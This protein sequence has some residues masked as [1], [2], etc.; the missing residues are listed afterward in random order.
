MSKLLRWVPRG[1]LGPFTSNWVSSSMRFALRWWVHDIILHHQD[2]SDEISELYKAY[3]LRT[4]TIQQW[5]VSIMV[6][7]DMFMHWGC[8]IGGSTPITDRV[9][10][11]YEIYCPAMWIAL[12]WLAKV[13]KVA[14]YEV[15]IP[16]QSPITIGQCNLQVSFFIIINFSFFHYNFWAT[17]MIFFYQSYIPY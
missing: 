13:S 10:R 6:E 4:D 5:T 14:S 3:I 7:R 1:A 9:Y 11:S 12:L 17:V 2:Q 8:E 16:K 15:I